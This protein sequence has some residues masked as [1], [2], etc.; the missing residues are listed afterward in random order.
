MNGKVKVEQPG[1]AHNHGNSAT[2]WTLGL[3]LLLTLAFVVGEAVA[4]YFAGSLALLAD[5]G[6]NF[7]DA[8]ALA[9]SWYAVWI[10]K[11]PAD[12]R[13]TFGYHRVG[14]LAALVNALS[15]V[16]IALAIFWEAVQ[17]FGNP[18]PVDAGLMIAV[19]AVAVVLNGLISYWLHGAAS[20]DLNVRS[21]YLHM[22][23]DA[24]SAVGVVAAGVVIAWTGEPT[25][26]AVVSLLIG[27]LI[28]WSSWGI[29]REAVGILLE[30][31]PHGLDVAKVVEAICKVPGVCNVH[32]LHVWTVSSGR[33]ACSCHIRV[34][35][36]SVREGQQIQ[37]AVSE[38][39]GH[40]FA[41]HHATIQVEVEGCGTEELH[42]SMPP[43]CD[44]KED[45]GKPQSEG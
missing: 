45:R 4:S 37:R 15:L 38:L 12:A 13:R 11:R 42:C 7:I 32:D 39:L 10:G 3:S 5:A 16:G 30:A 22:L 44:H 6:H 19:A 34:E 31:A 27:G 17:R 43:G 25:A 1:M 29:V 23:G 33:I 35:E 8:L 14:V 41:I 28:L 9:F 24:L 2:G 20:H 26:D 21:A 36:Q 18:E 40:E